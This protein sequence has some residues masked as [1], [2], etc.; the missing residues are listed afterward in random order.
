MGGQENLPVDHRLRHM[1]PLCRLAG[2]QLVLLASRAERRRFGA[3]QKV[4]ERGSRDGLDYFL[5]SGSV[6]L[7]AVDGRTLTIAAQSDQAANAIARLQPRMFRVT[8][9]QP[10]EF[11]VVEQ[12]V[13]NQLLRQAPVTPVSSPSAAHTGLLSRGGDESE[14]HRLLMEFYGDLR[15]NHVTLPGL[16]DVA[17]KVRRAAER[18]EVSAAGLAEAIAA[19]PAMAAK[20]V[21]AC[22]GPL[23]RGFGDVRS[24]P[25]AVARL[26][27]ETTRKLVTEFA[28]REV[29]SSR[30]PTV[31]AAMTRTWHHARDVAAISRELADRLPG[32]NPEEAMLAGLLHGLGAVPV[33]VR[34]EH[35]VELF[36]DPVNLD[37]AMKELCPDIGAAILEHWSFPERFVEVA[38]HAGS[39]DYECLEATPQLVDIVIVARLHAMVGTNQNAGLPPFARVPAY[40]RL[41][42]LGLNASRS[43]ELLTAA[44]ARVDR[45]QQVLSIY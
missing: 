4:V 42:G 14:E 10:C 41:G 28:M 43:L 11:L 38:R 35:H 21:R 16:P 9:H 36:A 22:N 13:L 45:M 29:F 39:W 1:Q 40:R 12:D 23:F 44:R 20:L 7:T 19:D 6:D 18:Q 15:V 8:A 37:H 5:L 34:A 30:H 17:W 33:L 31:Q 27:V 32:G 25:E 24:I 26:G 3:G 2:D